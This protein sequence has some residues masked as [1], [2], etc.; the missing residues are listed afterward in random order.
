MGLLSKL[1]GS[2]EIQDNPQPA[3]TNDVPSTTSGN[4]HFVVEAVFTIIGRGTV[5]TG[6]VDSGEIHVGDTV[7]IS[8][9]LTTQVTGV[10]MFRKTLD[11]AKAGDNCGLL[12]KDVNRDDIHIGDY[13]T[14]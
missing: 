5:V 2:R 3:P 1:F 14:K 10:E 7:N 9:R 13:L 4:F 6:R 8:G 12:L 11:V